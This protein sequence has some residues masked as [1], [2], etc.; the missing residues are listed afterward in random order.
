MY[1]DNPMIDSPDQPNAIYFYQTRETLIDTDIY[2]RFVYS[3]E[4]NFRKSRFY[5]DYKSFVMNLGLNMDQNMPAITSDMAT[6]EMH[7]NLPTLKQ[8]AIMIIEHTLNSQGKVCTFDV[9]KELEECHR[10]HWIDV[11]ILSKTQ[12]QMH[13]ANPSDF[14]STKQCWGFPFEFINH[15]IDGMTLDISFAI[16]LQLKME[17]QYGESY[18]PQMIKARDE[19]LSWQQSQ[20]IY[21]QQQFIPQQPQIII[22]Y[23]QF[24]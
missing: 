13:H 3:C 20:G 19:I 18:N 7:H 15:Y 17:T 14:I 22:P 21:P 8:A 24:V 6:L 9:V 4:N 10:K 12:H 23:N 1:S 2:S 11:I 5:K 16:L